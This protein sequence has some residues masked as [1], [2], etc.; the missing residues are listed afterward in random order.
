MHFMRH[1]QQTMPCRNGLQTPPGEA[2]NMPEGQQPPG[3]S[4]QVPDCPASK[5]LLQ[6]LMQLLWLLVLPVLQLLLLVVVA[7][8]TQ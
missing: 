3:P 1:L 6:A 7:T 5:R 8:T 4:I 2:G